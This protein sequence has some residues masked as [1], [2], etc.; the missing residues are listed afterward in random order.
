MLK[1]CEPPAGQSLGL[2]HG[3]WLGAGPRAPLV[4]LAHGRSGDWRSMKPFE[5]CLRTGFN[6][7]SLQGPLPDPLGGFSWWRGRGSLENES[8]WIPEAE[9]VSHQAARFMTEA[10]G[11]YA[12]NPCL[13]LGFGFS[14]G[15]VLLS[16]AALNKHEL[17]DGLAVLAGLVPACLGTEKVAVGRPKIFVAHGIK[18]EK[19]PIANARAAV[20][21]LRGQG[22]DVLYVEDKVGH[23]VGPQGLK[24]LSLWTASFLTRLAPPA[25]L[26]RP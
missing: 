1:I 7:I 5:R 22:L 23:K 15:G 26:V 16:L 11:Y 25:R 8:D 2:T 18:D 21:R 17:F 6:I 4:F 3:L 14:Q 10:I 9:K 12:L 24:A 13:K 20:E 19:L